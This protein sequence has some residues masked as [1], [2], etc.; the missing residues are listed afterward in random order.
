MSFGIF[1][2]LLASAHFLIVIFFG[3]NFEDAV[4]AMRWQSGTIFPSGLGSVLGAQVMLPFGMKRAY[5]RIFRRLRHVQCRRDCPFL[6][7]FRRHGSL[8]L[9]SSNRGH[10]DRRHGIRG[11]ARWNLAQERGG[12]GPLISSSP[13]RVSV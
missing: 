1:V 8:N 13:A 11:L 2:V 10:C 7:F 4:P 5:M 6:I 9:Y 12:A 3:P